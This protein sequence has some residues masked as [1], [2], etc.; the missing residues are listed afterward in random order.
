MI[1][2]DCNISVISVDFMSILSRLSLSE[3]KN[4]ISSSSSI[5]SLLFIADISAVQDA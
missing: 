2:L 1:K 4:L 5:S 3:K